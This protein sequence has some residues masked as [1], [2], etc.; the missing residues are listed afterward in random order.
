MKYCTSI[1]QH[2]HAVECDLPAGHHVLRDVSRFTAAA[3][4]CDN[5]INHRHVTLCRPAIGDRLEI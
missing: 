2:R 5:A 1:A 4:D 3:T